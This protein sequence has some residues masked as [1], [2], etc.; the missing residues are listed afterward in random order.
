MNDG[1]RR[2]RESGD[3]VR[4]AWRECVEVDWERGE[5]TA[6]CEAGVN[7]ATHTTRETRG[8][9]RMRVRDQHCIRVE[10]IDE[11]APILATVDHKPTAPVLDQER[12]MAA[13]QP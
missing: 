6:C 2:D 5:C 7:P 13:V 9:V 11:A 1:D 12:A 3:R 4:G 10:C 8:M